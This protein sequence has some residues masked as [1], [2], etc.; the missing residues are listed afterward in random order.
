MTDAIGKANFEDGMY[1]NAGDILVELTNSEET[2]QLAEAKASVT[3]SARQFNRVQ[4]LIAQK[5]TSETQLDTE[6][7][8][9]QTAK[10]RLEAILARL[11]DRLIRAPFSGILIVEFANQLRDQGLEFMEALLKASEV[12]LRPVLMTALSTMTLFVVPVFYNLLARGTGPPGE[13]AARLESL[14]QGPGPRR[15]VS[16]STAR[17]TGDP[18]AILHPRPHFP[19]FWHRAEYCPWHSYPRDRHIRTQ[20]HL[21]QARDIHHSRIPS[22]WQDLRQ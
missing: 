9:E 3:E 5:L 1:V 7:T 19:G 6:Q 10:A 20:D 14:A 4:N 12:R 8:H 18:L 21:L 17:V 22:R 16:N 2:T 13:T 15:A 11:D